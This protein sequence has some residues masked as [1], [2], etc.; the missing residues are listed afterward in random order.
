[1]NRTLVEILHSI[2]IDAKLPHA[3]WAEA[4]STAVYLKDR[5]LTKAENMNLFE[6]WMN[7]KP[8]VQHWCVFGSGAYAHVPKMKEKS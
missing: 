5:S 6:A 2:L 4:V 7:D 8:Q 1:M 3:F